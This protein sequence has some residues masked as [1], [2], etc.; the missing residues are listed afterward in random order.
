MA[1]GFH[2]A[3]GAA[4]RPRNGQRKPVIIAFQVLPGPSSPHPPRGPKKKKKGEFKATKK[5]GPLGRTRK[6]ASARNRVTKS[7]MGCRPRASRTPVPAIA[8]INHLFRFQKPAQCQTTMKCADAI[9]I[10]C[11]NGGSQRRAWHLRCPAHRSDSSKPSTRLCTNSHGREHQRADVKI[12]LSRQARAKGTTRVRAPDAPS[13]PA[14]EL[15]MSECPLN[16]LS[17]VAFQPVGAHTC[18]WAAP[19]DVAM[20]V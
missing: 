11:P 5:R 15:S 6:E 9:P 16:T 17:S 2:N 10:F 1:P 4:L 20:P 7:P 18:L 19:L 8:V 14:N 13:R 3:S 12:D